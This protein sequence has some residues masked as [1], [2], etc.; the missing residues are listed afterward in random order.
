MAKEKDTTVTSIAYD[1]SAC[2][3]PQRLTSSSQLSMGF[4]KTLCGV[5]VVDLVV[6][7]KILHLDANIAAQFLK[8][9]SEGIEKIDDA[10]PSEVSSFNFL[11]MGQKMSSRKGKDVWLTIMVTDI[12]AQERLRPIIPRSF[13]A[14]EY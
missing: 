1:L 13:E 14:G 11:F 12:D 6:G 4:Q 3:L 2:L 7:R 8:L 10:Y 9:T 5:P